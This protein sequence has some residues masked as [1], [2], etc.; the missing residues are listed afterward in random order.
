RATEAKEKHEKAVAASQKAMGVG[1]GMMAGGGA[2]MAASYAAGSPFRFFDAQ[3]SA[4]QATGGMDDATKERLSKLAREEAK[5]SAWGAL[6][7]ANAQEYLAMAGFDEKAI[8]ASLRGVMNLAS[9]TKTGLAETADISTN[10]L[11]GFGLDPAEM[12][13]VS[14]VLTKVTS[15]ANTN[16]T[17][18]GG[19]MKYV[20]PVAK[21]AGYEIESVAAAAGLMANVGIKDSQAG[22]ALRASILRM[23]SLPKAARDAFAELKVETTD[24]KGNLRGLEYV[25]ADVAK[26]T[27]KMGSG[28]RLQ[29]LSAMFGVEAA[30]GLAELLDKSSGD[31]MM[32]Y[33]QKLEQAKGATDKA[34]ATRLKNLEGDLQMLFSGIEEVRIKYGESLDKMYRGII[35]F[36]TEGVAKI[37]EWM[38]ANPRMVK[39]IGLV[40]AAFG[41]LMTVSG[42]LIVALGALW[43]VMAKGRLMMFLLRW[44]AMD[45]VKAFAAAIL[46]AIRFTATLLKNIAVMAAQ[47]A[48]FAISRTAMAAYAAGAA[49]IRAVM[50]LATASQ[51][52]FN[53]ALSANPIGVVVLAIAALVA[54]GV[55]LYQNWDVVCEKFAAAWDKIKA[56]IAMDPME[57]FKAA[58]EPLAD[59]FGGLWD[60]I[61][62]GMISKIDGMTAKIKEF[63]GWALGGFGMFDGEESGKAAAPTSTAPVTAPVTAPKVVQGGAVSVKQPQARAPVID[64]RKTEITIHAAPGMDVNELARLMDQKLDE[65]DRKQAQANRARFG[66]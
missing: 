36:A 37:D 42:A 10:I 54:A 34:A 30:A 23:A 55:W 46:G 6:D 45:V 19:A 63:G 47:V 66:D 17:E 38:A 14:D 8:T 11:S 22:T 53:A 7:A 48:W 29:K 4:V 9:A 28:E 51:W 61:W 16:L 44:A 5:V 35:R 39:A 60:T 33:I 43:L 49:A 24:A 12:A 59:W 56:L 26:A 31:E 18:L 40:A 20:A 3:M 2:V 65:R 21:T 15:T 25:L 50:V 41:V 62:S 57:L 27:E 32:A 52:A 64:Q 58:W 13:R 1:A